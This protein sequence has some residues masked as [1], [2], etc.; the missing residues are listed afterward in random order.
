MGTF[1]FALHFVRSIFLY[2]LFF[3]QSKPVASWFN[4]NLGFTGLWWPSHVWKWRLVLPEP[5]FQNL[6]LI[7]PGFVILEYACVIR[8]E[9][10]IDGKTWWFSIFR[11]SADL[12]LWAHNVSEPGPEDLQQPQITALGPKACPVMRAP[13]HLPFFLPWCTRHSGTG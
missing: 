1:L 12:F 5:L 2:S 9:K 4:L 7:N 3:S 6:S 11:S 8:D 13:F 10:S